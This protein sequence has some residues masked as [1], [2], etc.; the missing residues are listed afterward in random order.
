MLKLL[1]YRLD[2]DNVL[3]IFSLQIL[4]S[5]FISKRYDL[6]SSTQFKVIETIK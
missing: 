4:F 5:L 2:L 3:I 6:T 1:L